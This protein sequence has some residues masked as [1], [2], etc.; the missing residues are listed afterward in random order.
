MLTLVTQSICVQVI[1]YAICVTLYLFHQQY[2][3]ATNDHVQ[4]GNQT[5]PI[6]QFVRVEPTGFPDLTNVQYSSESNNYLGIKKV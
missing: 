6:Q 1:L 5:R 4:S 3:V 2:R